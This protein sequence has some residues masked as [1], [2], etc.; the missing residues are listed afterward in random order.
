MVTPEIIQTWLICLNYAICIDVTLLEKVL[1]KTGSLNFVLDFT[2]Q[3]RNGKIIPFTDI[4]EPV[5][6]F[7]LVLHP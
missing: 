6:N 4:S 5:I 2:E 7:M 1:S 3:L